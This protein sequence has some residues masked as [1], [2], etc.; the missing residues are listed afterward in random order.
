MKKRIGYLCVMLLVMVF[1]AGCQSEKSGSDDGTVEIEFWSAPNPPQQ[2][3]WTDMAKKY[4]EETDGVKINVTPMPESPSSEAGIQSAIAAGSAP[5]ISENISRGFA[6]QLSDSSAI[7]PLNEF[8]GFEELLKERH[9]KE[10]IKSWKF[11]DGNQYVLPIYSNAMLFAWRIDILNELGFEEVPKTHSE[12]LEV[13]QKLKEQYPKKFLWARADLVKPTWWARWFDFFMIYNAASKGNNFV[14][15]SDLIADDQA[16]IATLE[17]FDKL[18]KNDLLLTRQ[19]T[20]P[21]ETGQSIMMDIGPWT[22]SYWDEKFPEMKLGEKY[23]LAMPPVPDG[24]SPEDAKT[25]ADTKGLSIYAS[26]TKEQQQA[27]FDFVKWVYSNPEHDL[28]WFKQT[29]LPPARDD[30]S[31]NETFTSYLEENPQLKEYAKNIPNA[32]PPIDNAETVAI[33]KLIGTNALIP[34]IKGEKSP[35]EAWKDMKEAING[36]LK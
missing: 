11:A 3:F 16:G 20:D 1:A 36:V 23:E 15:G 12:V 26:A 28:A 2:A 21:F 25:F 24:V 9:M 5:T 19:V 27:A 8:E 17:L 10:T 29:N 32:V 13:G 22:F 18:S 6:A 35:E 4:M 34:V 14:E 31:E 7:V 33:Q 30:L